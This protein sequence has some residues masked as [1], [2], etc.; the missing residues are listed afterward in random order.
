MCIR[1]N[2]QYNIVMIK[3]ELT[4]SELLAHLAKIHKDEM[5]MF[6]MAEGSFRGAFFNGTRLINQMR[7]QHN[8]GILETMGLGQAML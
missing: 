5:T 1:L 2:F 7:L 8:L 4:D 6:V 3:K